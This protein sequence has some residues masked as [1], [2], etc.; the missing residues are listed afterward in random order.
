ME[1]ER[2]VEE[3]DPFGLDQFLDQVRAGVGLCAC[4]CVLTRWQ[5]VPRGLLSE[6]WTLSPALRPACCPQVKKGGKKNALD[7]IGRSGAMSASAGGGNLDDLGAG[8]SGRRMNFT[9]GSGR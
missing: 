8:G 6:P 2:P 3:A 1:F 9:A 4:A 7:G 5:E